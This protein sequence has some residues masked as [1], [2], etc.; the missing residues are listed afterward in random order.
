MF[1]NYLITTFRQIVKNKIFSFINILGLAL[2]IAA[3]LVISQYVSF[4][5]SFDRF[6][7][8]ADRIF[9]IESTAYNNGEELGTAIKSSWLHGEELA[10]SSPFVEKIGRAYPFN[11]ANNSM[12]YEGGANKKIFEQK[13]VYF[14]ESSVFE[15]FDLSFVAGDGAKLDEPGKVVMTREN[16]IKFFDDFDDAIGKTVTLSGNSGA[17]KLE[18]VG[19]LETIPTNSHLAFNAL[20]SAQSMD[21]VTQARRQWGYNSAF[22][23]VLLSE[24][25]KKAEVEKQ[26]VDIYEKNAKEI[27]EAGGWQYDYRLQPITSIHLGSINS[28]DFTEGVDQ[29]IIIGLSAIALIILVIAWINYVNLSLAK[30][31]DRLKEVGVR[32][33]M[34]SSKKQ[35]TTLFLLEAFIMNL[36]AFG[37][38]L[39]IIQLTSGY[40]ESVTGLP[41]NVL[42]GP[43]VSALLIALIAAG[44][45][46]TGA[47]PRILLR[48]MKAVNVLLGK[49]GNL[50]GSKFRRVLVFAQFTIT[51][52]LVAGTLTVFNQ[53]QYMKEADLKINI[54]NIMVLQS[55]PGEIDSEDRDDIVKFRKLAT[56]LKQYLEIGEVTSGGEVPG[57]PISWGSNLKLKNSDNVGIDT[58]LI[59]MSY[60][61]PKFFE[62]DLVAG[63]NLRADDSAWGK[64]DVAINEKMAEMLG[65]SN[66]EDAVGQELEG[67]YEPLT[68]RGVL[69]NHHHTSLH[70]GYEP[71]AYIIS[72]W[73]EYYF[74]K[75]DIPEG[76]E[77][78]ADKFDQTVAN[79]RKEWGEIFTDYPL[80]YFFLDSHFNQ[81]YQAD[82]QF[83]KLFTGFSVLA[84]LI[85]CLGLL[86]LTSFT[87]QQR[88]KEV[89]IRKALGANLENLI[90][91]LSKEYVILV[92]LA[93]VISFPLSWYA[94]QN[95]LD[96]YSFRVDLGWWC[97]AIPFVFLLAMASMSI[98]S[99]I[100]STAKKNP[101]ESLRYE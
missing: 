3:C 54:D 92:A 72:G 4:H 44:S 101:V 88:T 14:T 79:V 30:T 85:A 19:I 63:R 97:F 33:C 84:I 13:G 5:Y 60:E 89:G 64:G 53:I 12:I 96:D 45:L 94:M 50:G 17:L 83:G 86:G 99:K 76:I 35:I 93:C 49:K 95:W 73:V 18:V 69:E 42:Q 55:P 16:A 20:I 52:F 46:L 6:H 98:I 15:I 32:M 24:A 82:E 58:R 57:E 62:I 34:G 39:G 26:L 21:S 11:Y 65:F 100:I 40:L 67:F 25:N 37:L 71:I 23:Y 91:L 8:N 47:Y 10:T 77:N 68:V 61:F 80:D 81:Q 7:S 1:K 66:P 22:N 78:R 87:I 43:K 38:A 27:M 9:R 74:I 29:R 75:F 28:S 36:L 31:I 41:V 56:A 2:G 70:A 51:C 90:L 48:A 59:S